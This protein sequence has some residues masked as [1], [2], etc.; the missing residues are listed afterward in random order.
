MSGILQGDV[1]EP[2]KPAP[3]A[4]SFMLPFLGRYAWHAVGAA[5]SLL[6]AAALTLALGQGVRQLIDHGFASGS[7]AQLNRTTLVMLGIVSAL[8]MATV[9]RFTLITWLGERIGADIR[10]KVFDHVISLSPAWF[11]TARTGDVLSRLTADTAIVQALAE[12]SISQWVRSFLMLL[13]SLTMLVVTSPRL[14]LFVLA[15]VPFVLG[16]LIVFS[17]RERR[18]ARVAQERVAD[19]ASEAEEMLG[20]L[21]TVQALN[22]EPYA[23]AAFSASTTKAV[24][25]ALERVRS[26]AVVI[27]VVILLGF[28]SITLALWL[29]G[30]EVMAGHMTEG[31]LCAFVFYS[32]IVATSAAGLS[33]LWG[34]LQRAAGAAD[35][36]AELLNEVPTI[37]SPA[38]PQPFPMPAQ[39]RV[40]FDDV[41]FNYPTRPG[42]PALSNFGLTIERGQT[43][44]LVGPSGAG[45]TTLFQLLLRFYDVSSGAIRI[46]GV[47]LR[48]CDLAALRTRVGVVP[49]EPVIFSADVWSNIRIGRPEATDAQVRAAASAAFCDFIDTLP[50]G[51]DSY[52]GEKGVRLSGGQRQRLAIARAILR[53]SPVLVLDEATSALDSQSEQ[54]VQSALDRLAKGRTTLVIAHRLATVRRADKIVV[55]D[56]GRIVAVGSHASLLAEGGLYA[57]LAELQFSD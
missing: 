44:A 53:D 5:F 35:R 45:K 6:A 42:H 40:E 13:G 12:S 20:A 52:L 47:D 14:S 46:D 37:A 15:V 3:S 30:R 38:Q 55:L 26:R 8:A 54:A 4:L 9:A 28:G 17:R 25:A 51:F 22:H 43:I 11:E 16:P 39:G 2:R 32:V 24:A 23:R 7:T 31:A 21:R 29:G 1:M 36:I 57:R 33:E 56:H 50:D 18:L 48:A 19:L 49:Q 41:S 27:L 10:Y 34:G